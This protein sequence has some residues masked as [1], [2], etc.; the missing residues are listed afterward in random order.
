MK[1]WSRVLLLCLVLLASSASCQTI[2]PALNL[3]PTAT[4]SPTATP[5]PSITVQSIDVL[6][7]SEERAFDRDDETR[8]NNC[9]AK[10]NTPFS[11]QRSV[12]FESTVAVERGEKLGLMFKGNSVTGTGLEPITLN[13]AE[14][15]LSQKIFSAYSIDNPKRDVAVR[16]TDVESPPHS[17]T[18]AKLKWYTIWKKGHVRVKGILNGKEFEESFPFSLKYN[19][20]IDVAGKA[21]E[22]C[23]KVSKEG[24]DDRLPDTTREVEFKNCDGTRTIQAT[25]TDPIDFDYI[26]SFERGDQT[27]AQLK[28]TNAILPSNR[29]V[30]LGYDA[31]SLATSQVSVAYGIDTRSKRA[32]FSKSIDLS[33][34]MVTTAKIKRY[35]IWKKGKTYVVGA[36]ADNTFRDWFVYRFKFDMDREVSLDFASCKDVVAQNVRV[37]DEAV[38]AKNFTTAV[39]AYSKALDY[40]PRDDSILV[41]RGDAYRELKEWTRAQQDCDLATQ[42]NTLNLNA[43]ACKAR[44][45]LEKR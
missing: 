9:E 17:V 40:A 23:V 38:K 4:P 12:S 43:W 1:T 19:A 18:T 24:F 8:K 45:Q 25:L 11:I 42:I 44:I 28:L 32:E 5:K 14:N 30:P 10:T 31:E 2:A 20:E 3:A 21:D 29:N 13:D 34:G 16:A 6:A 36:D 35:V 7:E 15:S 26:V 33:A 39:S 22:D 41:K 27:G 37:G